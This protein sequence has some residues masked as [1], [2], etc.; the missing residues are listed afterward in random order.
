MGSNPSRTDLIYTK[1]GFVE[2]FATILD[3][4]SELSNADFDVLLL[5]LSRDKGA[6]AYDGK[7]SNSLFFG[8]GY[9][10]IRS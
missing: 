4:E 1:E 7:V 2:S 8:Y 10:L 5:Y 6:I 3:E 9:E